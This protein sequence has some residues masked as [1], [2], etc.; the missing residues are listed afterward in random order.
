MFF[1]CF[2]K[3][4]S[5]SLFYVIYGLLKNSQSINYHDLMMFYYRESD[6]FSRQSF[7]KPYKSKFFIEY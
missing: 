1:K 6:I 3:V 7:L 5:Y 2:I 4:F